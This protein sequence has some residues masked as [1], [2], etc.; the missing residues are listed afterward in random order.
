MPLTGAFIREWQQGSKDSAVYMLSYT[1]VYTTDEA[2]YTLHAWFVHVAASIEL[3][4]PQVDLSA[5]SASTST[6]VNP[7]FPRFSVF[8]GNSYKRLNTPI[9]LN[10]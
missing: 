5:S 6:P 1:Y 8:D 10:P 3:A 7:D 9:S 4:A 2:C